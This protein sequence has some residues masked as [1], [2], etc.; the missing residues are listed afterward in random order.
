MT[1]QHEPSPI[2]TRHEAPPGS[3]TDALAEDPQERADAREDLGMEE[4]LDYAELGGE[5]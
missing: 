2:R 3:T 1:S 5:A 4:D